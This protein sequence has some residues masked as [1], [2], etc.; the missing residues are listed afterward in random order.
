MHLILKEVQKPDLK[1]LIKTEDMHARKALMYRKSDAFIIMPGG[2]G[3]L[4]EFFEILTWSH[5]KLHEKNIVLLNVDKYWEPLVDLIG[6]Q[7]QHG[8]TDT[9]RKLFSIA[10]TPE[11]AINFALKQID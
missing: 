4:D 1:N 9:T 7:I 2:L 3:T 5:L 8:F 11:D 6:H 10:D